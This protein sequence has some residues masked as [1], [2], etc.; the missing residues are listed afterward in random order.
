MILGLLVAIVAS[1]MVSVEA[2][3]V[4]KGLTAE[5]ASASYSIAKLVGATT[6]YERL[7]RQPHDSSA[8]VLD[9]QGSGGWIHL[10][11]A[12]CQRRHR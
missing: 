5:C 7:C 12:S 2:V 9:L 11:C 6:P 8:Q 10:C 4:A 1:S 3:C